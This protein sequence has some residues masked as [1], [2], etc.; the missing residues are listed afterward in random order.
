MDLE[1]KATS[2]WRQ[3]QKGRL[4]QTEDHLNNEENFKNEKRPKS[5]Y[6]FLCLN[7]QFLGWKWILGGNIQF[8]SIFRS[9]GPLWTVLRAWVCGQFL[10]PEAWGSF[11]FLLTFN[12]ACFLLALNESPGRFL[13]FWNSVP[14]R[15]P[16]CPSWPCHWRL[17]NNPYT[18]I[19]L[20]S[21]SK[22]FW[23]QGYLSP[24]K[25][26]FTLTPPLEFDHRPVKG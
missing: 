11:T 20:H 24:R 26:P 18:C 9:A 22:Q 19:M 7:L 2:K 17:Q 12:N 10:K 4:P 15:T 23:S 6:E 14:A 13:T 1:M 3:S 25:P 8:L 5:F 21:N 16:S